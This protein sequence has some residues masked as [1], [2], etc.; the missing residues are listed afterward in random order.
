M[1][2][3]YPI[4]SVITIPEVITLVHTTSFLIV[5]VG[6]ALRNSP[7]FDSLAEGLKTVILL[8]EHFESA[9]KS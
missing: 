8:A 9:L 1:A 2:A 3:D 7:H 5:A 6:K 4:L